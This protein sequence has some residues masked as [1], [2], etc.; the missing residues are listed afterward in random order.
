MRPGRTPQSR[1]SRSSRRCASRALLG[2]RLKAV[3]YFSADV[4]DFHPYDPYLY[5]FTGPLASSESFSSR[6]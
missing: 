6:D 1:P 4:L 3:C 2:A 5:R